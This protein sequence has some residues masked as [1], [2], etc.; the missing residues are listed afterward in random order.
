[1]SPRD[2]EHVQRIETLMKRA[3]MRAWAKI[4]SM[5]EIQKIRE[6]KRAG[7]VLK[8]QAGKGNAPNE[9]L[10]VKTR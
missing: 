7:Q 4:S 2:F 5:P 6:D 1:M 10:F 3:Q 9:N 8:H